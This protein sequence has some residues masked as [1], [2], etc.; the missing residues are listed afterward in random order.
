MAAA[1]DNEVIGHIG[2]AQGEAI[3]AAGVATV[4]VALNT[5]TR[6]HLFTG[7]LYKYAT[8]IAMRWW[9]ARTLLL[10][11]LVC[12]VPAARRADGEALRDWCRGLD[13]ETRLLCSSYVT[14][15]SPSEREAASAIWSKLDAAS[16]ELPSPKQQ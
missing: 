14:A 9:P 13:S 12:I 6:G 2:L 8:V 5:S 11:A 7:I 4:G 16:C 10:A 15:S 3:V 1:R